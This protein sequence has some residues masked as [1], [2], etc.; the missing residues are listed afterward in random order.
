MSYQSSS[1]LQK[2]ISTAWNFFHKKKSVSNSMT[3]GSFP[4]ITEQIYV[5]KFATE[6]NSFAAHFNRRSIGTIP[7]EQKDSK[8]ES[9][10]KICPHW[11]LSSNRLCAHKFEKRF[12]ESDFTTSLSPLI[13]FTTTITTGA[14][15]TASV[16][17]KLN[18]ANDGH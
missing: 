18:R 9:L 4:C 11:K 2:S 12:S 10:A 17:A 14:S 7:V 6:I 3:Y 5:H 16:D 13:R 15:H 8:T 1:S